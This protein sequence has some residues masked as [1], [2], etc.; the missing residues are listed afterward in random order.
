MLVH[1]RVTPLDLIRQFSFIH[2][3]GMRHRET[4]GSCPRTQHD[5]P[6]QF[7]LNHLITAPSPSLMD[8]SAIIYKA[9]CCSCLCL[10][11]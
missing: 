8:K 1:C 2:L 10:T 7:S 6:A 9:Q 11:G 3:D 5:E 4:K